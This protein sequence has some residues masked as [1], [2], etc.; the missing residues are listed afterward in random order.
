MHE[1]P[2]AWGRGPQSRPHSDEYNDVEDNKGEKASLKRHK[3][4]MSMLHE[5]AIL[6]M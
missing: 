1:N 3:M 2:F 6:F 4:Q 5:N